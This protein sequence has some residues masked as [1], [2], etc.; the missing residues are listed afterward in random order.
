MLKSLI[1]VALCFVA[2]PA[3]ADASLCD[4]QNFH[5]SQIKAVRNFQ[6]ITR[7]AF[8]YG[9]VDF[10]DFDIDWKSF[11]GEHP[12]LQWSL[13][14]FAFTRPLLDVDT[15]R[16]GDDGIVLRL[17]EQWVKANPITA[18]AGPYAWNGHTT[19]IRSEYLACLLSLGHDDGW[20]LDTIEVHGDFLANP[21]NYDGDWNH[22]L[23]QNLGLLALGC[24]ADREDWKKV[25]F[26]R[27]ARAVGVMVDDQGVSI[28]QSTTYHHYNHERFLTADKR[29]ENCG[30]TLPGD[31][32]ERVEL[33]P[34]FTAHS[35]L[36]DGTYARLGDALLKLVDPIKNT[37]AEFAATQ[38][39]SGPKPKDRFAV[40]D[41]GYV[42]GRTGWG[43]TRPF[44][45]ESHY[46]LRFGPGRIIHGHNDHTSLTYFARGKRV[47][48]DGGFFGY[49]G[50]D[51]R[52]YLMTPQAH[53]VVTTTAPANFFWNSQTHLTAKT[54]E[55][56]WQYYSLEDVPYAGT[57]RKR[58]V[59]FIQ[60]P[61][62]AIVVLD[63]IGG[64][65]REYEQ[66][67]HFDRSL[68]A[69]LEENVAT[70]S[71]DGFKM[72]VH[73]LG[74]S[75]SIRIVSGQD[76]R[77]WA[78]YER[79]VVVPVPTL[80]TSNTGD[81]V[82]FLSVFV[83]RGVEPS[84]VRHR[85]VQRHGVRREIVIRSKGRTVVVEL[86]TDGRL[87]VKRGDI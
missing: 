67:W 80:I 25:A 15:R 9:P 65:S 36:P 44:G 1:A 61:V 27:T 82:G 87:R 70:V 85:P 45:Q 55:D 23:D 51:R 83:I 6:I 74:E 8:N 62:E 34:V 10:S 31:M 71:R 11:A 4:W 33:M 35:T 53:N 21:D 78:G 16:E 77:G 59:L 39:Q 3:L 28:E 50:T 38:G 18:P 13:N 5:K 17:L 26:D 12:S 24:A 64:P 19:A 40:Y 47:I 54:I 69:S 42:F 37:V 63:N 72:D 43:E 46:S 73:Q 76:E 22:G 48:T 79:G 49:T 58:R 66:A 29:F 86:T 7:P 41:A 30:M 2:S 68:T 52:L 20:F 60:S 57:T 56:D 32:H 75:E 14:H 81:K 84:I